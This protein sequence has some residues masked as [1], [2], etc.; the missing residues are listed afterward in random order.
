MVESKDVTSVLFVLYEFSD[1]DVILIQFQIP[2]E[3]YVPLHLF[4][5]AIREGKSEEVP[6]LKYT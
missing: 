5:F 2:R 3:I 1:F 4:V 6:E